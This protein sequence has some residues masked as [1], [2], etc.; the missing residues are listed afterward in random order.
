M[1]TTQRTTPMDKDETRASGSPLTPVVDIKYCKERTYMKRHPIFDPLFITATLFCSDQKLSK[2]FGYLRTFAPIVFAHP[3]CARQ[4]TLRALREI[5][6]LANILS[7]FFK[8]HVIRPKELL[9]GANPINSSC[10][11]IKKKHLQKRNRIFRRDRES[12]KIPAEA[13]ERLS[14]KSRKARIFVYQC[15]C[16]STKTIFFFFCN[17]NICLYKSEIRVADDCTFKLKETLRMY[18][19]PKN[20][21]QFLSCTVKQS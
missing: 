11:L 14:N 18:A 17:R 12:T 10:S 13:Q 8:N 7:E 4:F 20:L 15:I 5:H 1:T 6:L 16:S 9:T 3:Y 2:S 19:D 21:K